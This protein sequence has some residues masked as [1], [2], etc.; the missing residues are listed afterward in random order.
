[1]KSHAL[2]LQYY[3]KLRP[4]ND[5]NYPKPCCTSAKSKVVTGMPVEDNFVYD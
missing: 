4:R 3:V 5:C 1:M 2:V